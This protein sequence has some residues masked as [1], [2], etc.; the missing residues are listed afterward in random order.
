MHRKFAQWRMCAAVAGA[1][2][3][4]LAI[5][6]AQPPASWASSASVTAAGSALRPDAT[7]PPLGYGPSDLR[8]AYGF[9]S[10][11]AGSG[12]TVAVVA[13][14]DDPDAETDM[15]TYRSEYGISPCTAAD[16]CFRKVSQTGGSSYPQPGTG[17]SANDSGSLDMISAVCPNCHI[18]LVEANDTAIGDL[19]MA[20]N[21]A[22]A[23]GAKF[24]DNAWDIPEA[25]LGSSELSYDSQYFDHPGVAITAPAGDK[26]YGT[27][28]YPAASQYVTAVGSTVLTRDASTARGWTETASSSTDSGCSAYEPK[29]GWQRDTGCNGRTLNDVA[30][31]G[32]PSTPVAYFDT[33]TDGGWDSN[34]NT[35][36]AAAII[37]AAYALAGTPAA[38]TYP[39]SYP[40]LHPGGAYTEPGNGYPYADGLNNI[41]NGSN[42]SL[43]DCT[44][45]YLCNAGA[46]YSGPAGLGTPSSIVSLS[47]TGGPSGPFFAGIMGKCLDDAGNSASNGNKVQLWACN[48]GSAQKWTAASDGTVTIHGSGSPGQCLDVTGGGTS[49]GTRVQLWSCISGDA[50]QQW[51][52]QSDG[53]LRNPHS[54]KCLNDPGSSTIN[55][56]WLDISTCGTTGAEQWYLP[57]A[58]PSSGGAIKSHVSA[59]KCVDDFNSL[60]GAGNKIQLWSCLGNAA[61]DWTVQPDGTVRVL[62][63]C[64]STI[65]DGTANGT[66][67]GLYGCTG[68]TNQHWVAR[69]DGSLL[70]TRSGTCLDDPSASTANGI[71]LQIWA[72]N[73]RVQQGWT[74]P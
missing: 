24:I 21:E 71:Q 55:G 41:T 13:P 52:P 29:P 20:E 39:A 47:S 23:L 1:A 35:V 74:L 34:G 45:T 22:V 42:T 11:T 69:S 31:V 50:N 66:R 40:Y 19:G 73:G 25:T 27:I 28:Y 33:P 63:R 61:Q 53:T 8:S 26:G 70:N 59:G 37:A 38:G 32:D 44:V 64:M 5:M 30:A 17:W 18:L 56:T 4:V 43:V 36:I 6:F 9:P 2:V 62:G 10:A 16:G 51:V 46:G 48:G 58:V 12:Q 54:G 67:V 60:T 49:N 15:G 14:Y 72:C 68:D 65:A 57:Y 3:V 7:T